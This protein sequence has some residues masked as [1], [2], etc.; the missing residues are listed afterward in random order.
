MHR[1][2]KQHLKSAYKIFY[3]L[4]S[5]I[6]IAS[7]LFINVSKI[8]RDPVLYQILSDSHYFMFLLFGFLILKLVN[9][10]KHSII[11]WTK[12]R[13]LISIGIGITISFLFEVIQP[14]FHRAFE[15]SDVLMNLWG[16][17]S[18]NSILYLWNIKTN[19][20]GFSIKKVLSYGFTAI[21]L[22]FTL[23]IFYGWGY[24]ILNKI[25]WQYQFPQIASFEGYWELK[26][27]APNPETTFEISSQHATHGNCSLKVRTGI[28]SYPGLVLDYLPTNWSPHQH[29]AFSIFNPA[30][31]AFHLHVRLDNDSMN[32]GKGDRIYLTPKI[33]P[34]LNVIKFE[35]NKI[36]KRDSEKPPFDL[37]NISRIV[38]FINRPREPMEFYLDNIR[39]E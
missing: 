29:F 33:E 34:G 13:F 23:Y 25:R 5:L 15:I 22:T 10:N 37:E 1:Q 17:V 14:F 16:I 2:T 9:L 32:A 36:Q 6:L 21:A 28:F 20:P 12:Q 19:I 4:G 31:Q 27:W 11:E 8:Q 35:L 24:A 30:E 26:R 7:L 39:L 3:L 38:F 18:I